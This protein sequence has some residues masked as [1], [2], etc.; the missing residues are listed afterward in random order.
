MDIESSAGDFSVSGSHSFDNNYEYH[1]KAYLSELLSGKI[2]KNQNIT[3]FGAIEEDGLG[4]TSLFLKI[5]GTGNNI[6]VSYDLKAAA[7][8]IKQSLNREK[9]NLK[10]IFNEE[11]GWYKRDTAVKNEPVPAPKFKIE[12]SETEQNELQKDTSVTQKE[13]ILNRLFKRKNNNQ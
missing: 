12:W 7:S 10:T 8:K 2:I 9:S 6:K 3:E 13:N 5:T 11:Y 1:I 4:R